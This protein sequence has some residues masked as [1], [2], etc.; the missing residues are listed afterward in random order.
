MDANILKIEKLIKS[1]DIKEYQISASENEG[2]ELYYVLDKLETERKVD[3]K[4]ILVKIYRDFDDMKGSSSFSITKAFSDEEI[5]TKIKEAYER[6][7]NV[8][9][10]YYPLPTKASDY[11][12]KSES[13][14][15]G[16]LNKL[17]FEVANAIQKANVYKEG[18]IN[19]SE[20]FVSK[21]N[22]YFVNSNG[23][24]VS[25][26]GY[27]L[28]IEVIPTWCGEKEE[29]ELYFA[30]YSSQIELDKITSLVDAKL[31]DAKNRGVA[32]EIPNMESCN[33]I[34]G[35]E[36]TK[37][38]FGFFR[39]ELSYSAKYRNLNHYELNDVIQDS[40]EYD[41]MTLKGVGNQKASTSSSP[42]DSLGTKLTDTVLIKE[43]KVVSLMG[44]SRFGYY[45][46][47]PNP[48]GQLVNFTVEKGSK[49][50]K[51]MMSKPYLYCINFSAFQLDDFSG[52]FGGEV[53]LGMY[54]DGEKTYPV[55]GFSVAGNIFEDI[56]K[57]HFSE[58]VD[59][60][61]SYF[62]P[63]YIQVKMNINK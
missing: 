20:I 55:T 22:N 8:K 58:E 46:G 24:S 56:K 39:D 19:S 30:H 13:N 6:A 61:N 17:A 32:K 10:K 28:M 26:P 42:I 27:R 48:T 49:S 44:D 59:S 40:D 23:V 2:F 41:K 60:M 7:S 37:T 50:V 29:V 63:K 12:F 43:G 5:L 15:N 31:M 47:I 45:M 18:W 38:I 14:I 4:N 36:E 34:L 25:Y 33:V 57:M 54:F 53:R 62:G 51:E 35:L 52:Y 11:E 16:D 3:S 1:L 21:T 9:N